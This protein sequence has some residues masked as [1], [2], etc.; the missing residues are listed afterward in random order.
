MRL[1]LW[2]L[3]APTKLNHFQAYFLRTWFILP[4]T[5]MLLAAHAMVIYTSWQTSRVQG[6]YSDMTPDQI[7]QLTNQERAQ[8][9]IGKLTINPL[10]EAAALAKAENMIEAEVFEHYYQAE[11]RAVSPW[12]FVEEQGYDYFFAGENLGKDF[13]RSTDLVQAWL[14]SPAHRENLLNPDYTEIG[15]AVIIGPY[16]DKTETSLI[17][18]LFATP[19]QVALA[20]NQNLTPQDRTQINIAPLLV[21]SPSWSQS[22]LRNY[23]NLLWYTTAVAVLLVGISLLVDVEFK[24][25]HTRPKR[26]TVSIDLWSH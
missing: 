24:R 20:L 4:L 3:V 25:R 2:S 15:V 10:L 12:Q 5:T 21:N 13:Q 1:L 18:Q 23:P 22:M 16:L 19:T 14:D 9:G 7:Y 11:G 6:S 17:V 26:E 8:A